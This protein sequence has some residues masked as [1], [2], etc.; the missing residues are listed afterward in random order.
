MGRDWPRI[1]EDVV[2]L[3]LYV[4]YGFVQLRG[5]GVDLSSIVTTSAILTA[6][7][8]FAMQDTPGNLLGG[9]AIQIDNTIQVG[10]WVA[11]D[12]VQG[13]LRDIRSRP[14]LIET[15]NQQSA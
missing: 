15:R 5:A 12:G 7:L 14:T 1:V 13:Q 3:V 11:I 4:V 6:V 10:D 2:S 8:A 9:L